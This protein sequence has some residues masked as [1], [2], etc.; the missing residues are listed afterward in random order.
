MLELVWLIPA[1]P[2]AG[3]LLILLFGRILGEPGAGILATLMTASSFLVVV[4]VYF[5]HGVVPTVHLDRECELAE[6]TGEGPRTG[7][8]AATAQPERV[9][10]AIGRLKHDIRRE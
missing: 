4:G 6:G 5:D 9:E 1:L 8:M 7:G 3:F 2:L 10:K